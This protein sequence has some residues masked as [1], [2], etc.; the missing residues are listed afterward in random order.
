MSRILISFFLLFV[1]LNIS[2]QE[3][4][5]K[6]EYERFRKEKIEEF[7]S[8]R[9]SAN[10]VYAD[11][12]KQAWEEYGK[13]PAMPKPH[14]EDVP[15][16]EFPV[17]EENQGLVPE[18]NP[19]SYDDVVMIDEPDSQP[20]PVSPIKEV[21]N[22]AESYFHFSFYNTDC[23]V[24]LGNEHCFGLYDCSEK[25]IA[26]MWEMMSSGGYDN[27]IRDCLEL[28]LRY[29]L[30]DWAYLQ[31][32]KTMSDSFYGGDSNESTLLT[33]FVYCQTG[34]QTRLA[35]DSDSNL[36][37]LFS[38]EHYIYDEG[39]Y[40]VDGTRFYPLNSKAEKLSICSAKFPE[41]KPLSL[42][43]TGE[44]RLALEASESRVLQ[45]EKYRE[46]NASVS[47]NLN[48]VKFYSTYPDSCVDDDF[49]TR[50]AMYASS[51]LNEYTRNLLYSSLGRC[52]D[53]LNQSDAVNRIL[54]FVQTAFVYEY[55]DKLWGGDRV[56]FPEETL[57]YPYCDCEDR[58]ILF[59]MLI[60]DLLG[61]EV[62]LVYYPGH[63]AAAVAF[64]E[65]VH[66]DCLN[67]NG[68]KY[69]VCDPTYIG[70]PIGYTM[71]GMDNSAA[72]VIVL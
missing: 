57:Y 9:D 70:A 15:P 1:F 29:R 65:D 58:A 2:A 50:W 71:P 39:Y 8:F 13:M 36:V 17:K 68:K 38:S 32:L 72:T 67:V 33:A 46:I 55:D 45:A 26:E 35:R 23:K 40:D 18:D 4:D 51:V 49:G 6:R 20:L 47:V 69:V 54:N 3:N 52:I 21:P 43:V 19:I 60:R 56:F 11:F 62:V 64:T 53:G 48:L 59:S 7:N 5:F 30:C 28:R 42:F 63:L 22:P 12:V 10:R 44:Q 37:L 41:E 61:L 31:M 16:V 24:R 27:I 34:Y 14:E 25:N 66:G